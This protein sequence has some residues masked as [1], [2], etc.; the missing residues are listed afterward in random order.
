MPTWSEALKLKVGLA[1]Q[2]ALTL[3]PVIKEE[4]KKI[5]GQPVLDGFYIQDIPTFTGAMNNIKGMAQTGSV[6]TRLTGENTAPYICADFFSNV[7]SSINSEVGPIQDYLVKSMGKVQSQSQAQKTET[8]GILIALISV[9]PGLDIVMTQFI[10][11][12]TS[13]QSQFN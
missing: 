9:V 3:Y 10:H 6:Q 8:A 4:V 11:V 13:Q 7:L 12:V 1:F 2:T 5:S